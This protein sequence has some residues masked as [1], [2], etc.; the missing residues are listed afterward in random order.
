[1]DRV[2]VETGGIGRDGEAVAVVLEAHG[3]KY[4]GPHCC[5][6]VRKIS[7]F[8]RCLA[9][10]LR[11]VAAFLRNPAELLLNVAAFLRN[12]A[13]LLQNVAALLR[14]DAALR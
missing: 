6:P 3:R 9:A 7:A 1:M 5:A 14:N 10:L 13:A 2:E 4:K 12:P 11:D 8:L